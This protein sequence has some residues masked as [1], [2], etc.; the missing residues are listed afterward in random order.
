[1]LFFSLKLYL[2]CIKIKNIATSEPILASSPYPYFLP[3]S[4]TIILHSKTN[5]TVAR[6]LLLCQNNKHPTPNAQNVPSKYI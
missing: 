1:M 6:N 5:E 3:N 4:I 2:S